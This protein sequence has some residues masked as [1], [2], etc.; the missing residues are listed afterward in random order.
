[1]P[2]ALLGLFVLIVA[3]SR[4]SNPTPG[5]SVQ[6]GPATIDNTPSHPV[7]PGT[8]G[9]TRMT[10]TPSPALQHIAQ[11]YLDAFRDYPIGSTWPFT[12]GSQNYM[13]VLEDHSGGA[14]PG[15]H[16]GISLFKCP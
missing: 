1:M 3:A 11:Q 14:V 6:I 12:E 8:A 15:V 7:G 9:C 5:Y 4:R 16:P 13:A 2:F 10:T